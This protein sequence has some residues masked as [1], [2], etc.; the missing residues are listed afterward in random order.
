MASQSSSISAEDRILNPVGER[1]LVTSMCP[2]KL[3][4]LKF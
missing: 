1:G 4:N 2:A 3:R